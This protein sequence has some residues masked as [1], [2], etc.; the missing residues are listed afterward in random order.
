MRHQ[1]LVSPASTHSAAAAQPSGPTTARYTFV[2]PGP[3]REWLVPVDGTPASMSAIEY[4]LAH[5]DR[6]QTHV[7]LVNVQRP[8][9]AGDVSVLASAKLV[10]DLRRST[11]ERIVREAARRLA[12]HGVRHTGEVIFAAPAEAIVR[13][14]LER[15]STKIVMA[16]RP[17]GALAKMVGRSVASRVV[18]LS[19]VPVTI[20]KPEE[21]R[22]QG[23]RAECTA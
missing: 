14:A 1:S 5:A 4:V 16:S 23:A 17:T 12:F 11:G 21:T 22:A 15:G 8:V 3:S 13:S 9:M 20:V 18:R 7:H 2:G 19:H 10:I 6:A